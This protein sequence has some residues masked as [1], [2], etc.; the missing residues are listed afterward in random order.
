MYRTCSYGCEIETIEVER[1]TEKSVWI[2]ESRSARTS[3]WEQYFDTFEEA[4]NHLI[5]QAEEK[6]ESAKNNLAIAESF[7]KDVQEQENG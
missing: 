5:K 1:K 4:K 2:N 7:L 6:I 3:D